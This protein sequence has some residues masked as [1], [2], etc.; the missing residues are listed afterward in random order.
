M[1]KEASQA[2]QQAPW[3]IQLQAIGQ[4]L[5]GLVLAALVAGIYLNVSAQTAAA[6]VETEYLGYTRDTLMRQIASLRTEIGIITSAAEMK[7]RADDLG[8]LKSSEESIQYVVIDGYSGKQ[9]EIAA[10]PIT[11]LEL[12][13]SILKPAYTQSLWEWLYKSMLDLQMNNIGSIK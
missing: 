8:F 4:I 10:P 7:K 2:F 3:R 5:V 12:P 1:S 9:T 13:E 11:Q 6:A